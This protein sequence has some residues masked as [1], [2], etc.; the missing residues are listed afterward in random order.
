MNFSWSNI[1]SADESLQ[2]EFSISFRYRNIFL[3]STSVLALFVIFFS[4]F[5]A[6]FLFLLGLLYWYYL[7]KAKHYCF[8][9]KRMVLVDS[10]LGQ[11]VTSV[12][13][14][15]ITDVEVE[16][17]FFDQSANWGTLVI[18]TA[19]T[20]TPEVIISFIDNPLVIKKTLDEIR[21]KIKSSK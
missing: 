14:N 11:S 2:K 6:I 21:D 20:H 13:Y 10:F 1:L 19:G 3:L 7:K 4:I 15:Q 9:N 17:S 16:Q 8:T 12:D 5:A 18:N